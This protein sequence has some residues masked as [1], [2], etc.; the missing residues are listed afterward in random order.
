MLPSCLHFL[1][2]VPRKL[3]AHT[4]THTI[5]QKKKKKSGAGRRVSE[6]A[7]AAEGSDQSW[8]K[9][10]TGRGRLGLAVTRTKVS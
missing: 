6:H 5:H 8:R 2:K 7:R 4:H 3:N 1:K 10:G 9:S